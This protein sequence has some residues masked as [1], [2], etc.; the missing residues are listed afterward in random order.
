MTVAIVSYSSRPMPASLEIV[1]WSTVEL[2][3]RFRSS[4]RIARLADPG[5]K[6]GILHTKFTHVLAHYDTFEQAY[7]HRKKAFEVWDRETEKVNKVDAV[8]R[9]LEK[10]LASAIQVCEEAEQARRDA[11]KAHFEL[12]VVP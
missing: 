4:V 3:D 10:A 7:E 2:E 11:F 6:T 5:L 1:D 8:R 12:V 9:D